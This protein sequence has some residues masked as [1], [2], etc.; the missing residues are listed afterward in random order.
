MGWKWVELAEEPLARLPV[1]QCQI[2][3]EVKKGL[4]QSW[5][6]CQVAKWRSTQTKAV[7]LETSDGFISGL[8][9]RR[10]ACSRAL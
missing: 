3:L 5:G 2:F 8:L 10:K 4:E 7:M 6:L 9:E 1:G